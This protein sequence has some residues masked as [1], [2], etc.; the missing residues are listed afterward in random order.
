MGTS[1]TI[2]DD[3]IPFFRGRDVRI[4]AHPGVAGMNAGREWR[5]SLRAVCNVQLDHLNDGDL[6]LNDL[7]K[8]DGAAAVAKGLRL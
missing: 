3:Y 5:R 1:A 4:V 8:R 7:V 6:D 2:P